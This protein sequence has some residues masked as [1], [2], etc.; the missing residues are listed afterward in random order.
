MKKEESKKDLPKGPGASYYIAS[1]FLHLL[2]LWWMFLIIA[3]L[4]HERDHPALTL[5]LLTPIQ[6]YLHYLILSLHPAGSFYPLDKRRSNNWKE[7]TGIM[8]VTLFSRQWYF[9]AGF[10]V[11]IS[12][13]ALIILITWFGSFEA[14]QA[15]IKSS[16]KIFWPLV[17]GLI[18]L[19]FLYMPIQATFRRFA[20]KSELMN[21]ELLRAL[22]SSMCIW[23]Y[24]DALFAALHQQV[25]LH[26]LTPDKFL[27]GGNAQAYK[28][29]LASFF[30]AFYFSTVTLATVGYGDNFP[31]APLAR[32]IATVEIVIGIGLLGFILAR[33]AGFKPTVPTSQNSG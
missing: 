33:A 28:E 15:E 19:S 31:V 5:I 2:R 3:I 27:C 12:F 16:P 26:C 21:S 25:W 10:L 29:T 23:L 20:S 1:Y 11:I 32:S 13:I 22:F 9:R 18:F 7:M 4:L 17:L 24:F 6:H 8:K 30:D 14:I